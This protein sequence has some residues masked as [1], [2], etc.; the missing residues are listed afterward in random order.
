MQ[1][2][3]LD[4]GIKGHTEKVTNQLPEKCCEV[5]K[6]SRHKGLSNKEIAEKYKN[7]VKVWKSIS[8]K[9]ICFPQ[10]NYYF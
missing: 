4:F 7:L 3:I 9:H 6:E 5:F 8:Q 2:S 10:L 1:K